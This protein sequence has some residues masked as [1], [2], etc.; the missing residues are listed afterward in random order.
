[1]P[2]NHAQTEAHAPSREELCEHALS[3]SVYLDELAWCARN[4]RE[5]A[6]E[7]PGISLRVVLD[8]LGRGPDGEPHPW[9]SAAK[10]ALVGA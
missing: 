9:V 4:G 1:M 6:S 3:W 2:T 5:V 10:R 8:G 7:A